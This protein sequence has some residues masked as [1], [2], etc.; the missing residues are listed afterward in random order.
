MTSKKKF[1]G[2]Y[3]A[4]CLILA[5]SILSLKGSGQTA[6]DYFSKGNAKSGLK[7]YS[8][9]IELEPK[10]MMGYF[11]RGMVKY[12]LNDYNGAIADYNTAIK[13]DAGFS[14][15]YGNRGW[16]K[17]K[18]SLFSEAIVDLNK[19]IE[20]DGKNCY[21]F[22]GRAEAKYNLNDFQ[23]CIKDSEMALSINLEMPNSYYLIGMSYF[24]LGKMDAAC[25]NWNKAKESGKTEAVDFILKYCNK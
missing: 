5:L 19:A 18:L 9:A 3:K 23:G 16:S 22:D 14:M 24:K 11:Y 20:L 4:L 21:A 15:A 25:Q 6:Q 13:I 2:K 8:K 12:D 1:A 17:L 10:D 7:I